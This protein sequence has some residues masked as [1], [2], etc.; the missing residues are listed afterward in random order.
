MLLIFHLNYYTTFLYEI[1]SIKSEAIIRPARFV[2]SLPFFDFGNMS[3]IEPAD[4]QIQIHVFYSKLLAFMF[5]R[6]L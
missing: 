4:V 5:S 6:D 2:I 3:I 1:S